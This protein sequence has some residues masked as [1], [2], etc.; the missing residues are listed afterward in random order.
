MH[1]VANNPA[2]PLGAGVAPFP[3]DEGLPRQS[4]GSAPALAFSRPAQ[5]SYSLHTRRVALRPFTPEAS[6]ISL[7]TY[8]HM[9]LPTCLPS[10]GPVCRIG[11]RRQAEAALVGRGS[12]PHWKFG[13]LHSALSTDC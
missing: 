3:N 13:F 9:L 12:H 10:I 2:G 6:E 11:R 7:P 1:A 4:A 5:P 8:P